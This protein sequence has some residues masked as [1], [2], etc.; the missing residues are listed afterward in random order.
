MELQQEPKVQPEHFLE[1]Y[2]AVCQG[3]C[4]TLIHK[5]YM[6]IF[7]GNAY[8]R[9]NSKRWVDAVRRKRIFDGKS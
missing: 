3:H 2:N 9:L 8:L 6:V 1:G 5:L 4:Y 7:G